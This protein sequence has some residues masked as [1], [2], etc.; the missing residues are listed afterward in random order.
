MYEPPKSRYFPG[1]PYASVASAHGDVTQ[2][3]LALAYEIRT[4]NM[5][6]HPFFDH[7]ETITRMEDK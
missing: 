1:N 5:I 7:N 4:A 3:I 2:A 6:D